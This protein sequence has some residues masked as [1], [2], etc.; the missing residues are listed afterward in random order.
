M[1]IE[2]VI[3]SK[4]NENLFCF[5]IYDIAVQ[6]VKRVP[7][8]NKYQLKLKND[9]LIKHAGFSIFHKIYQIVDFTNLKKCLIVLEELLIEMKEIVDI[10]KETDIEYLLN[11]V[12]DADI[13][14]SIIKIILKYW[15]IDTS[16]YEDYRKIFENIS[17]FFHLYFSLIENDEEEFVKSFPAYFDFMK[18]KETSILEQD[19]K[20][21]LFFADQEKQEKAIKL[22]VGCYTNDK[23]LSDDYIQFMIKMIRNGFYLGHELSTESKDEDWVEPDMLKKFLNSCVSN[24]TDESGNKHL[25]IDYTCLVDPE[26]RNENLMFLD[27]DPGILLFNK[28]LRPVSVILNNDKLKH[29]ITHPMIA[30]FATL[31]G[32]KFQKIHNFNLYTFLILYVFP[33]LILFMSI[34]SHAEGCRKILKFYFK[35]KL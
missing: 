31:K 5:L 35:R 26:I 6:F 18:M 30:L 15:K 4:N 24:T 10:K 8:V 12:K 33:F 29:L 27:D 14:E 13:K 16:N 34:D 22:I 20:H 2:Y 1:P 28:S 21:L 11:N 32:K 25:K 23:D 19:C 17:P 3:E 9:Q 7:A